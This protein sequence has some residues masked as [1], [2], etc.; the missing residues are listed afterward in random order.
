MP[1]KSIGQALSS[2]AKKP[3][4]ILIALVLAVINFAIFWIV[5]DSIAFVLGNTI[6]A[7]FASSV[8]Q[9]PFYWAAI[10]GLDF[11][12]VGIAAIIGIVLQVIGLFAF[13]RI[14]QGESVGKAVRWSFGKWKSAIGAGI[15]A[16][17]VA[18]IVFW[19]ALIVIAISEWN[20]IIG[21]IIG[22][23]LA[24]IAFIAALKLSL[25]APAMAIEEVGVGDG[26]WKSWNATKKFWSIFALAILLLIVQGV[27]SY[28]GDAVASLISNE[29]AQ[30]I[31]TVIFA[32][33]ASTI[34]GL[35]LSFYY[36]ERKVSGS[37]AR[38][39]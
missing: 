30:L 32:A 38:R 11:W 12:I 39:K 9:T 34:A 8:W 5:F 7:D 13:A 26:L 35:S 37:R 23:I 17:L 14:A 20:G 4:S 22:I 16:A 21:I 36:I 18:L 33:V 3:Q 25:F 15:F 2:F 6:S 19:I 27:L 28:I 24:V 10:Q 1:L 29:Y 31:I